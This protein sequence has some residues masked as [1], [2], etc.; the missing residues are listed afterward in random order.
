[1]GNRDST[2]AE[3]DFATVLTPTC[4]RSPYRTSPEPMLFPQVCIPFGGGASLPYP[5]VRRFELS[6]TLVVSLAAPH[7]SLRRASSCLTRSPRPGIEK[8]HLEHQL[9]QLDRIRLRIVGLPPTAPGAV[10]GRTPELVRV[11]TS[12]SVSSTSRRRWLR[13]HGAPRVTVQ[14]AGRRLSSVDTR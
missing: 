2:P 7:I 5:S 10:E 6:V 12:H 4:R 9:G 1:M 13:I 11:C 14:P 3:S 8:V